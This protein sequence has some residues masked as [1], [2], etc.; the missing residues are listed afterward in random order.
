MDL[1]LKTRTCLV[2]GA[3]RGIGRGTAKVMAAEGCRVAIVARRAALLE[4]LADEIASLGLER[5][6]VVAEDLASD[7]G[8]ERVRDR[9]LAAFDGLD[10]LINNAG[11]SRPVKWDATE[12]QWQE[13]MRLNFELVRRMTNQF[14]PAMRAQRFGRIINVTGANEPPGVNI[15]SVAK[16]GLHNWAKGLSRELARDGITVNCVPPGR[17]NS[18]QILERL[19][20]TPENRQAFIDANIPIGFF[21]EPEDMAYLIAFLASP[22]ARYITGEVIHVDGGMHR[23]A[24]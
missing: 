20:P 17:I 5:P 14:I 2:T 15:A 4:E 19:H 9:V 21:G 10:V 7:G 13:G 18:E 16:A 23:F 6:L 24:G 11:S 12:E 8:I 22:L 1:Q 3:S